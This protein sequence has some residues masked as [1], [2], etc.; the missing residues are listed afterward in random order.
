MVMSTATIPFTY[1]P[2]TPTHITNPHQD[3]TW[4]TTNA[5]VYYWAKRD[6]ILISSAKE[7]RKMWI[8][9]R[10]T[11]DGRVWAHYDRG[12]QLAQPRFEAWRRN[13]ENSLFQLPP[14]DHARVRRL[15]RSKV[16]PRTVKRMDTTVDQTITEILERMTEGKEILNVVEYA[17]AF[18][19]KVICDLIGI[20]EEQSDEFHVLARKIVNAALPTSDLDTLHSYADA[21][22]AARALFMD[23]VETRRAM[24]ERPD[25]ILTDWI[26]ANEDGDRLSNDELMSLVTTFFVAGTETVSNATM[27]AV[28]NLLAKH[29]EALAEIRA[30]RSLLLSAL[31]E[32]LR[33][34]YFSQTGSFRYALE[35]FEWGGVSVRKGQLILGLIGAASRDPDWYDEPERF[36]IRRDHRARLAFGGGHHYCI[37]V[38]LARMEMVHA[39]GKLL[40]DYYPEVELA[41]ER[42][43][44]FQNR[45]FREI[46]E[47]P[48]R[49]GPKAVGV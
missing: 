16:T 5:P 8:D 13:N 24:R 25:D 32:T 12:E 11:L 45:M 38:Q 10:L 49:L 41:G 27:H 31:E 18:P 7:M 2:S 6:A 21:F 1:D 47:L 4:L 39:V 30:D 17:R 15:A 40:I 22:T 35:D 33:W 23:V 36:D 37:G 46:T 44:N 14:V 3:W 34:D 42:V 48:L 29:P 20:P 19:T 9:E 28:Y 26:E 43:Y